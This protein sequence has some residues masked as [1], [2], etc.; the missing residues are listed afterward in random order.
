MIVIQFNALP[1]I[2]TLIANVKSNIGILTQLE[3]DI[4]SAIEPLRQIVQTIERE[5]EQV[6]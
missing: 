5:N 1:I 6:T 2:V 3:H 4:I